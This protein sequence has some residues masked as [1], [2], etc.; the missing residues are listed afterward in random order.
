[1]PIAERLCLSCDIFDWPEAV[2]YNSIGGL[3]IM[4]STGGAIDLDIGNVSRCV[5]LNIFP[6]FRDDVLVLKANIVR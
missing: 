5:K 1:M 6:E 2:R 3:G 4:E